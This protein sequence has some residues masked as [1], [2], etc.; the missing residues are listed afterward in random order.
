M[1]NEIWLL[2]LVR[3]NF[4]LGGCAAVKL[5]TY[6]AQTALTMLKNLKDQNS[7]RVPLYIVK[8]LPEI[9]TSILIVF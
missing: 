2:D 8:V 1:A 4:E 6:Y 7:L 9:S 5:S 3:V